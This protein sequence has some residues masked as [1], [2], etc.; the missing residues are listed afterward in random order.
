MSSDSPAHVTRQ[1]WQPTEQD[2][3]L[4]N[5]VLTIADNAWCPGDVL[6]EVRG[7]LLLTPVTGYSLREPG[8]VSN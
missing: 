4:T 8:L 5:T 3:M 7:H 2:N 1:D 6:W